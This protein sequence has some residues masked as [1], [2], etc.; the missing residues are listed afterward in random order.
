MLYRGG[1]YVRSSLTAHEDQC[2][3]FVYKLCLGTNWVQVGMQ[4]GFDCKDIGHFV[5]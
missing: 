2:K 3:N 5:N 4:N 1:D